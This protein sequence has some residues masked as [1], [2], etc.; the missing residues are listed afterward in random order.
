M[1]S[2]RSVIFGRKCLQ[3][4][5]SFFVKGLRWGIRFRENGIALIPTAFYK[6]ATLR[7]PVKILSLE[8]IGLQEIQDIPVM[9]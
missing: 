4:S 1:V 2:K 5:S 6:T 8:V 3:N 7:K 9:Q